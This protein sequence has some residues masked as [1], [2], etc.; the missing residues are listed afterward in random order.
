[1]NAHPPYPVPGGYPR[2]WP[3]SARYGSFVRGGL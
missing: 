1:M 2:H 3:E